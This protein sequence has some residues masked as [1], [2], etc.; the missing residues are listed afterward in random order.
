MLSCIFPP[1]GL[2]GLPSSYLYGGPTR[3]RDSVS[4]SIYV[5]EC[6]VCMSLTVS[7]AGSDRIQSGMG[8]PGRVGR[9]RAGFFGATPSRNSYTTLGTS[10]DQVCDAAIH[11]DA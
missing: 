10:H 11:R 7:Q 5:Y 2:E 9:G 3:I 4:L 1:S 8:G 6:D